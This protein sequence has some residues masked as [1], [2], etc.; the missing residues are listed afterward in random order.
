VAQTRWTGGG[1]TVFVYARRADGQPEDDAFRREL[2]AFMEPCR[3]MGRDMAV[4]APRYVPVRIQLRV[5]LKP[6]ALTLTVH[7]ELRKAFS[8]ERGPDGKEEF[9]CPYRFGFGQSVYQSQVIA[10]AM[11]VVGVERVE[12]EQF[13][14]ADSD[15]DEMEIP[16]GPREIARL[17]RIDFKFEGGL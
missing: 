15:L 6:R 2:H 17:D 14:R 7:Q 5:Y 13:R 10:R 1:H 12:V 11:A 9:F 16:V 3:L 8:K 4:E